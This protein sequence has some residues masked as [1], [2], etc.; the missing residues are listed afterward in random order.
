[1]RTGR[2][3]MKGQDSSVAVLGLGRTDGEEFRTVSSLHLLRLGP[4]GRGYIWIFIFLAC[5]VSSSRKSGW[6]IE[7]RAWAR[8]HVDLPLRL[9][10]PYSVTT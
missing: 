2:G 7:V 4:H 6:A 9:T 10:M 8:S 3:K 5:S 1:M